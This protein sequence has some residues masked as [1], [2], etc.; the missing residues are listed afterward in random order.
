VATEKSVGAKL[1]KPIT[2]FKTSKEAAKVADVGERTYDAGKLILAAAEAGKH[3]QEAHALLANHGDGTF[4]KWVETRCGFCYRTARRYMDVA[5][6]FGDV[7]CDSLSQLSAESL[8]FLSRNTTPEEAI[9][10]AIQ[11]AEAGERARTQSVPATSYDGDMDTTTI[12]IVAESLAK[13]LHRLD[14]IRLTDQADVE[15]VADARY[16]IQQARVALLDV[17][18]VDAH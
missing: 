12:I 11:A 9:A 13:L 8:Y 1:R 18:V 2:P 16:F 15:A 5:E 3:L 4:G 17:G 7:S 6:T 10:D 14:S